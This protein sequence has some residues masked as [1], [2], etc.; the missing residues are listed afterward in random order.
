MKRKKNPYQYQEG[1]Y[2]LFN[3]LPNLNQYKDM[4]SQWN[5]YWQGSNPGLFDNITGQAAYAGKSPYYI[6]N[7]PNSQYYNPNYQKDQ[8]H[9]SDLN[10]IKNYEEA[11]NNNPEDAKFEYPDINEVYNR[12]GQANLDTNLESAQKT[13]NETYKPIDSKMVGSNLLTGVMSGLNYL[14]AYKPPEP[15]TQVQGNK[16]YMQMGGSPN[17]LLTHSNNLYDLLQKYNQIDTAQVSRDQFNSFDA[18]TQKEWFNKLPS[19]KPVKGEVIYREQ[20]PVVATITDSYRKDTFEEA[21]ALAKKAGEQFFMYDKGDGRGSLKYKVQDSKLNVKPS[22]EGTKIVRE[23][24]KSDELSNLQ[25]GGMVNTTGYTPGTPTFNNP[26]N[27]IPSNNI[28]M[29][30]TPFNVLGI[31]NVGSPKIMS[32]GSNHT[33]PKASYVTEIPMFQYGGTASEMNTTVINPMVE[34]EYIPI[35][36]EKDETILLPNGNLVKVKADKLHKNMK[37]D[38]VTDYV[39]NNSYIFSNDKSMKI[40]KSSTVRGI[41]LED[42][43]MGDNIYQYSEN[44]LTKGSKEVLFTD[45]FK[46][47]KALTPAE[48]SVRIKDKFK[49]ID[50]Q[51]YFVDRANMENKQQRMQYF[52]VLRSLNEL[53]KPQESAT[54]YRYG[55][56]VEKAQ[57]GKALYYTTPLWAIGEI[58]GSIQKKKQIKENNKIRGE[59]E[60]AFQAGQ[61][62]LQ[63][64]NNAGMLSNIASYAASLN[65]PLNR[66]NDYNT[67]ISALES[68]YNRN[69]Q[70]LQNQKYTGLN[71][72]TNSMFNQLSSNPRLNLNGL[73]S[74]QIQLNNQLASNITS[75][76][77]AADSDYTNRRNQYTSAAT[78]AYN[79]A[80]NTRD[81]QLYNANVTGVSN[82]GRSY[83]DGLASMNNYQT[84][85]DFSMLELENKLREMAKSAKSKA[86]SEVQGVAEGI[87]QIGT[88]LLTSGIGIPGL[89]GGSQQT[90]YTP[91]D[92]RMQQNTSNEQIRNI[93]PHLINNPYEGSRT[94]LLPIPDPTEETIL[95]ELYNAMP[96]MR[97]R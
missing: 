75:Q 36:T 3:F 34:G 8:D 30:N 50:H 60:Q 97:F 77:V 39:P 81:T 64:V 96:Y 33:F 68:S 11:R 35:Q 82:I 80:L 22:S 62:R 27:V 25:Q 40:D 21:Y 5:N 74:N 95:R 85:R 72:N 57:L 26:I 16:G 4:Y 78:D 37:R 83:T 38:K 9:I 49:L 42:I 15:I 20:R 66:T 65:V 1:G 88:T 24:R 2:S 6:Y 58:A 79:N 17:K 46:K 92:Y 53:K 93:R 28:T 84:N 54:M 61:D 59:Y 73:L 71:G 14:N 45:L 47:D 32:P 29:Q 18:Q 86:V 69:N 63:N 31:P 94:P 87:G 89:G 55:G 48:L 67:E 76:Q 70:R 7:D 91:T 13:F 56:P 12:I 52:D 51:D 90:N 23:S 10:Y 43:S 41:K 44:E 19:S